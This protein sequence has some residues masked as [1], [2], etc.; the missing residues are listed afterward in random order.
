MFT[1]NGF[2]YCAMALCDLSVYWLNQ[3][4]QQINQ[5]INAPFV[6]N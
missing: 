1:D 2:P 4:K 3:M 6:A 5:P